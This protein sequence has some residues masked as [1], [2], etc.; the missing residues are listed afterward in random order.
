MCFVRIHDWNISFIVHVAVFKIILQNGRYS[1]T[2][3]ILMNCN[4]ENIRGWLIP[5]DNGP[6]YI[7]KFV[8]V[9][10][11][12]PLCFCSRI[13][14]KKLWNIQ[15]KL[16][17]LCASDHVLKEVAQRAFLSYLRS[18]FLMSNKK[19]FN[20]HKLDIEKFSRLVKCL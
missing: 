1:Q 12:I 15:P 16:S 17:S 4:I 7:Q 10:F 6:W 9:H 2:F 18:V 3:I 20:V 11:V 14:P 8:S 13:N 5:S 19:V